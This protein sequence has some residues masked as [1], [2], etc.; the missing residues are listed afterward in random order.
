MARAPVCE[1]FCVNC[2]TRTGFSKASNLENLPWKTYVAELDRLLKAMYTHRIVSCG[3]TRAARSRGVA[4]CHSRCLVEAVFVFVRARFASTAF[5]FPFRFCLYK[6]PFPRR[7]S[8]A[9]SK[10]AQEGMGAFYRR[11]SGVA[12]GWFGGGLGVAWG[13]AWGHFW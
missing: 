10:K 12:R 13:I 7:R 5:G 9:Q 8:R 3:F 11:P 4:R 2:I 1:R 6:F